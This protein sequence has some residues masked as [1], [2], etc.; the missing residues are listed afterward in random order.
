M[1]VQMTADT[2]DERRF[3]RGSWLALASVLAF[4]LVC[5]ITAA[6]VLRLP[7]DGCILR[8]F[9]VDGRVVDACY[10]DWPT[11]L[12]PGDELLAI[13]GVRLVDEYDQFVV[14]VTP[15]PGWRAGA[16]ID[17]TVRRSGVQIELAVPIGQLSWAGVARVFGYTLNTAIGEWLLYLSTALIFALAPRRTAAQ[18]F[19]VAAAAHLAV[20]KLGWGGEPILSATR[21]AAPPLFY[22]NELL[23]TFW[24]WLFWPSLLLL[25][26]SFPRRVWPVARWPRLAPALF[27][28]APLGACLTTLVVGS[29][30]LSIGALVAEFILLPLCL[31]VVTID[32]FWRVRDR[33]VRAQT[34][35]L[36]LGLACYILPIVIVYPLMVF[37]PALYSV[38]FQAL[39]L[40]ANIAITL[41][42]D[43]GLPLCLGIA[44]TRYR[45]FDIDIIIHRTGV[46][47]LYRGAP[48][49][50][51][52]AN[53]RLRARDRGLDAG[54]RR[55]IQSVAPPHPEP[56]RQALL[57]TQVRC[58]QGAGGLRHDR[59]RRDRFGHADG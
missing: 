21:F 15:P 32:T 38:S 49:A 57:S 30:F 39:P 50:G 46:C 4:A 22:I 59:T 14:P 20:T 48:G 26:L 19:F 52:S 7:N 42:S 12:R 8:D 44:I 2:R 9:Q 29:A 35:W 27:Y 34:G 25:V 24:I 18:L 40:L 33:T 11:T 5:T 53:W 1:A 51:G 31:L 16:A 54:D 58:R 47:R 17:Y 6:V 55:A 43:L 37:A 56:N 23:G 10:G 13:G 28:L 3:D 36:V 41:V 45:L